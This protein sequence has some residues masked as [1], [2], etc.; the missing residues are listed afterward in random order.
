M[1][2][3]QPKSIQSE[4]ESVQPKVELVQPKVPEWIKHPN[5]HLIAHWKEY[6]EGFNKDGTYRADYDP[7]KDPYINPL[8]RK[9]VLI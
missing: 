2:P 6:P 4:I 1:M 3:V 7:K 8:V 5:Q 9:E